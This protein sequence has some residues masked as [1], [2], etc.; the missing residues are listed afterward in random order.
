MTASAKEEEKVKYRMYAAEERVAE[1]EQ[2]L[3]AADEASA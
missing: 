1:L 2:E 3:E